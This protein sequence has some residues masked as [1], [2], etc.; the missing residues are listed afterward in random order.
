MAEEPKP[1]AVPDGAPET[2]VEDQAPSTVEGE[3]PSEEAST[4][5]EG[6]VSAAKASKTP[7]EIARLTR[8][9]RQAER[10]ASATKAEL[11]KLRTEMAEIKAKTLIPP[12]PS[13]DDF[14]E[15]PE[16]A[17]ARLKAHLEAKAKY[18]LP[19]SGATST[20]T[21]PALPPVIAD[22]VTEGRE[23][24]SDWQTRTA[25][26]DLP[27]TEDV[28][29]TITE[30][31]DDPAALVY[32]I[33]TN[34]EATERIR[35]ALNNPVRLARELG[36]IEAHMDTAGASAAPSTP[37]ETGTDAPSPHQSKAAD[38]I[39]PVRGSDTGSDGTPRDSDSWEVW[40]QKRRAQREARNR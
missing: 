19:E 22:L 37:A 34:P 30:A 17:K 6:E 36:R 24:F 2:P 8:L 18:A 12:E 3:A 9:R 5:E 33:A 40:R 13:A 20:E 26:N 7:K 10:E 31:A 1:A 16:G 32:E 28:L 27:F 14:L 35:Q 11:A 25:D 15:D 23:R 38:P 29:V 21:G 4:T 39:K